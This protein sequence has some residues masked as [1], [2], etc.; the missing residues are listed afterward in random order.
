MWKKWECDLSFSW[1][2]E[3]ECHWSGRDLVRI[4]CFST[5]QVL[6]ALTRTLTLLVHL[7]TR[8]VQIH[9]IRRFAGY[10]RTGDAAQDVHVAPGYGPWKRTF[11][12]STTDW[13]QRGDTPK[14]EDDGGNLWKQLRS[15]QELA[16]DD[17]DDDEIDDD[18]LLL[19]WKQKAIKTKISINVPHG[20]SKQCASFKFE[21]SKVMA[22]FRATIARCSVL[23]GS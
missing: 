4:I 13:T 22:R 20:R 10:P 3:W 14:I 19:T 12:R 16:R 8:H 6:P 15:S 1:K 9:K 7:L 18:D 2:W 17:D 21:R 5:L 11:S 23:L